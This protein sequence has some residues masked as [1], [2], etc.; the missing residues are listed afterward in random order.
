[1][2]AVLLILA[3]TGLFANDD[4]FTEGPLAAKVAKSTSDRLTT[5]HHWAGNVLFGLVGLHVAAVLGYLLVK[6]ENL[7]RPMV[8]GLKEGSG[9]D[10]EY[11][12]PLL[13][14]VVL[15]GVAVILWWSVF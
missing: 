6:K 15:G 3:G 12:S 1:M 4:I 5:F 10:G 8:T 14:L 2:L 11:G 9:E 13:A 7:I